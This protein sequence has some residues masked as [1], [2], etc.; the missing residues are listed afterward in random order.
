MEPGLFPD[1]NSHTNTEPR[2]ISHELPTSCCRTSG[3][4]AY[5]PS[6]GRYRD[7]HDPLPEA[8]PAYIDTRNIG[9][10][11]PPGAPRV[12]RLI[13]RVH[14]E[15]EPYTTPTDSFGQYRVYPGRPLTIPDSAC[16]LEDVSDIHTGPFS[17]ATTMLQRSMSDLIM[18]CPNVSVF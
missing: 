4:P 12:R 16:E 3:L 13:L 7:E 2:V 8:P 15:P 18:P 5:Q 10:T 6:Q 1:I 17:P 9:E 11:I 14:P